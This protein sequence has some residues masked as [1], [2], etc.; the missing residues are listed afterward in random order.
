MTFAAIEANP[1]NNSVEEPEHSVDIKAV[2]REINKRA[3]RIEKASMEIG[4]YV[5]KEV[6]QGSLDEAL[7]RNPYKS[8]S[9]RQIADD[10]ELIISRR[11][12]ATSVR[13]AAFRRD[14][15]SH[16][17]DCS[18]LTYSHWAALLKETDD[19]KR[20]DLAAE[21]NRERWTV[22]QITD[23]INATK[24]EMDSGGK[25]KELL[26]KMER[27]LDLLKDQDALGL[28]SDPKKLEGQLKSADRLQ[29]AKVI[30][31]IV[32]KLMRSSEILKKARKSITQIE[33][34]EV[35]PEQA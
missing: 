14:L 26:R 18:S 24:Q 19:K 12:L 9:L 5:L 32:E 22:R 33:L 1:M 16:Q 6:F 2:V 10:P 35:Y 4:E 29:M 30:D 27:P 23:R 20:R 34:G 8:R 21:A 3:G 28:L 17:V 25:T 31:D 15:K 11:R 13:A 7:S